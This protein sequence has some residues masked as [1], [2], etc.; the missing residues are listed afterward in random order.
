MV[1]FLK[2]VGH[3]NNELLCIW[4]HFNLNRSQ[5]SP[6]STATYRFEPMICT[7]ITLITRVL[8]GWGMLHTFTLWNDLLIWNYLELLIKFSTWVVPVT[9]RF[10]VR[11]LQ[12]KLF[13]VIGLD[14]TRVFGGVGVK[15][16]LNRSWENICGF[17][18]F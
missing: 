5:W 3:L 10:Q 12:W 15:I 9:P 7:A 13:W 18:C 2:V 1:A 4:M 16:P 11:I 17:Y 6:I 14:V 8:F